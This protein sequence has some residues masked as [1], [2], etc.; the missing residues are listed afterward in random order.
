[1]TRKLLVRSRRNSKCGS[2]KLSDLN[3]DFWFMDT[4]H[5]QIYLHVKN[6]DGESWHRVFCNR[7]DSP[8]LA[9]DGRKLYWLIDK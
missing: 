7:G 5:D 3:F 9:A 1:M 4:S 2:A 8:R 6:V